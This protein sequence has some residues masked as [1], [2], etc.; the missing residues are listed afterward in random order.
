M[1]LGTVCTLPVWWLILMDK[2]CVCLRTMY[3]RQNRERKPSGLFERDLCN[4]ELTQYGFGTQMPKC[5][6][7]LDSE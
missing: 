2:V 1:F 5:Y 7:E 4:S 3:E 6:A